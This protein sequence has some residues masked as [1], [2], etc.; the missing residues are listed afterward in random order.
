[1]GYVREYRDGDAESIGPR[2]R[3]ADRQECLAASG[4]SGT[5]ALLQ[6]VAVSEILC[7]IVGDDGCPAGLFGASPI[8]DLAAAVWLLGT[9]ALVRPPLGRQFL[10]ES[11][12]YL[13]RLH[14]YRPLLCNCV[15]ERNTLHIRWL[16]WA[17]CTFINR[18]PHYGV[19]QR[20][21]LEFVRLKHV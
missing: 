13:D 6:S 2:L 19:E 17:G 21:F 3:E 20:P 9:D 14:A 10:R 7:T 4:L 18:H 11:R 5:D 12:G 8:D 1:V 16:T 15:D